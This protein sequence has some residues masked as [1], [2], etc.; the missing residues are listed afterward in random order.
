MR[1]L[2][3]VAIA[4]RV[5]T[6]LIDLQFFITAAR[7]SC[8][9]YK[10]LNDSGKKPIF[11][12]QFSALSFKSIFYMLLYEIVY[13]VFKKSVTRNPDK[14]DSPHSPCKLPRWHPVVDWNRENIAF[15]RH[16]KCKAHVLCERCRRVQETRTY[17]ARS[18]PNIRKAHFQLGYN[19][20][21]LKTSACRKPIRL[22]IWNYCELRAQCTF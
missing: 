21:A 22:K 6:T 5:E 11:S 19:I 17:D 7:N 8:W 10:L 18:Y 12:I 3:I 9:K 14:Y 4:A 2:L 16:F 1:I 13:Y 15:R 20:Q